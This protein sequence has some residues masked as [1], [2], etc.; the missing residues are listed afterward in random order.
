MEG[1][2]LFRANKRRGVKRGTKHAGSFQPG[3]DPRRYSGPTDRSRIRRQVEDMAQDHAETAVR[4]LADTI[5]DEAA[6]FKERRASAELL[7]SYA[8]GSPVA[9]SVHA[10]VSQHANREPTLA[11]LHEV[12]S[13][14]LPATGSEVIDTEY[15][16][17]SDE[18]KI[19]RD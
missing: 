9:R 2:N 15:V 17:N 8:Y 5:N 19:E 1:D 11:Q 7:L 12:Y 16:E 18:S 13:P 10:I 6:P 3:Y 4:F 14:W